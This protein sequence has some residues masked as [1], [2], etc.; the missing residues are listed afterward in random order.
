MKKIT[1]TF[2]MMFALSTFAQSQDELSS[3]KI[4]SSYKN[5]LQTKELSYTYLIVEELTGEMYETFPSSVELKVGTTIL[6]DKNKHNIANHM[7]SH[8]IMAKSQY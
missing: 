8:D 5:D 6:F 4:L 3:G 1:T 2:I 7:M